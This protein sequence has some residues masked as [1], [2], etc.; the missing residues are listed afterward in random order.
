MEGSPPLP[1]IAF[2]LGSQ[3][4]TWTTLVTTTTA[5]VTLTL[6]NSTN[7]FYTFSF[8]LKGACTSLYHCIC[9]VLCDVHGVCMAVPGGCILQTTST[10][11]QAWLILFICIYSPLEAMLLVKD[12]AIHM[13]LHF[14]LSFLYKS[15][16]KTECLYT[17]MA[18]LLPNCITWGHN[19]T[20][21]YINEA[22][23]LNYMYF[24]HGLLI[25]RSFHVNLFMG[26]KNIVHIVNHYM[27]KNEIGI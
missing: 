1:R 9:T 8:P 10:V 19:T 11:V 7:P 24:T 25:G 15:K 20:P 12:S 17:S 13:S 21:Y 6:H 3:L 22:L 4:Y 14:F 26:F 5:S 16:S 23:Y 27:Y 2:L 18:V